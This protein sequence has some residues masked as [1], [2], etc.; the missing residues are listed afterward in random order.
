MGGLVARSAVLA[1]AGRPWVDAVGRLVT[2]GAPHLGAPLEKAATVAAW[3]L[4]V[5]PESRPLGELLDTRS[6]G[7]KDLRFGA[8][9]TEDGDADSDRLLVD[10]VGPHQLPPWITEHY[11]AAVITSDPAHPVGVALG[12]LVV[13]VGSATGR[14]RRRRLDPTDTAVLPGRR[15]LDV[16][17]DPEARRLVVGWLAGD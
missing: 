7:I 8:L 9:T 16:L 12:D 3:G 6:A 13:R 11:L 1:G 5:A 17:S 14:G 15:H 10:S 4:R 2:L